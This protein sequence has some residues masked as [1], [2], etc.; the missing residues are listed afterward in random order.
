MFVCE[1]EGERNQMVVGWLVICVAIFNSIYAPIIFPLFNERLLK[2]TANNSLTPNEPDKVYR[3]EQSLLAAA[4]A[5]ATVAVCKLIYLN[6]CVRV[7][8]A[9]VNPYKYIYSHHLL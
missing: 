9:Y 5:A 4:A 1:R 6:L 3:K 7:L 8:R 2:Y